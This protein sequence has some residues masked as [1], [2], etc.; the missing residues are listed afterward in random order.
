LKGAVSWTLRILITV[1]SLDS[2]QRLKPLCALPIIL[3]L[4]LVHQTPFFDDS[5]DFTWHVAFAHFTC[6][7]FYQRP[8]SLIFHM[9]VRRRMIVVPHAHDDSKKD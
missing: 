3:K 5:G 2:V 7:N 6:G 1:S 4:S 9:D 8:K